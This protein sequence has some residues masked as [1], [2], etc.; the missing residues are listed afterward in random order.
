MK[1]HLPV[2]L[3]VFVQSV[4]TQNFT[5][6]IEDNS[7][8]IEEAYNQEVGVVQHIP[9]LYRTAAGGSTLAT[10]TQE[11]PVFSQTHQF[12][13]TVPY[14]S[15]TGSSGIGDV[16][17]NYRYQLV[18]SDDG[19]AVAPRVSLILPTGDETKGVGD[20]VTGVQLNL[21]VSKRWTNDV[22]THL[23]LSITLRPG[24]KDPAGGTESLTSAFGGG[25]VIW[26]ATERFNIMFEAL[27]TISEQS[28]A[29][30]GTETAG[31]TVLSPGFRYAVDIGALQIVPGLAIP[32]TFSSSGND[33][34]FFF[35]LSFEHP[36]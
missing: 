24:V 23:N 36:F 10:F 32:F 22:V 30:G 25:S 27:H 7:F 31:E 20:G 14:L 19:L 9:N 21:P 26:L 1:R 4:F 29:A 6:A 15:M 11:W 33:N 5:D 18:R 3:V 12:S 17:L 28:S 34:G 8:F 35:Y 16:M 13:Y 2:L